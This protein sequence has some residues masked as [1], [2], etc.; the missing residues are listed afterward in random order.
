MQ[1][2]KNGK[3]VRDWK[4]KDQ[5]IERITHHGIGIGEKRLA[6]KKVGIPEGEMPA[7]DLIF[8]KNLVVIEILGKI[9][10][11]I[12]LSPQQAGRESQESHSRVKPIRSGTG[13][14]LIL[15]G[16]GQRWNPSV[17]S[18]ERPHIG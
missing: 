8:Q 13:P 16:G 12:S 7:E 5:V 2:E 4:K 10:G 6:A 3:A 17:E 11:E 18:G 9:V 15:G 14:Q 1:E